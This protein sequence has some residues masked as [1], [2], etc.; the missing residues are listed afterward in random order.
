MELILRK[1]IEDQA[2]DV[3]DQRLSMVTLRATVGSVGSLIVNLRVEDE[4]VSELPGRHHHDAG[5]TLTP[6]GVVHDGKCATMYLR[7]RH[8]Q[9]SRWRQSC[10][11]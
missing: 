3:A 8:E 4:K 7:C 11:N 9:N 2:Y 1:V 6:L 10:V 5:S